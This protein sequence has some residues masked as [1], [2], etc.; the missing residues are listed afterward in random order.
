MTASS[1]H[2]RKFSNRLTEIRNQELKSS[3]ELK[4][5]DLIKNRAQKS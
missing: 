3:E 2:S 4:L 1:A 5:D